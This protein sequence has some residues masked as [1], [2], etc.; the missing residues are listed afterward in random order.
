[1][2]F[3]EL[4]KQLLIDLQSIFRKNNKDLPLSL[5]QVIVISSIPIEGINMTALSPVSYT[6]LTLPTN[7]EV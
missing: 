7:R 3:A 4:L 1:M 5:A 6:H 2:E